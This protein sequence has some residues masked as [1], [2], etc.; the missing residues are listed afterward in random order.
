MNSYFYTLNKK[1][2]MLII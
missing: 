1:I 2:I